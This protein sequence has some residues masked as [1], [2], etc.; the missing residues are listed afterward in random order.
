MLLISLLPT[1]PSRPLS[2]GIFQKCEHNEDIALFEIPPALGV[3]FL[4]TV[5]AHTQNPIACTHGHGH[6]GF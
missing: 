1:P 3:A 2:E 5:T 6:T 4:P